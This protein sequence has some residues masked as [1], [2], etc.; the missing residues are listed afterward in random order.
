MEG[1]IPVFP[2]L[3]GKQGGSWAREGGTIQDFSGAV[4][5]EGNPCSFPVTEEVVLAGTLDMERMPFP[6]GKAEYP[7]TC[8]TMNVLYWVW[9]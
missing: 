5:T 2:I 7:A 3:M 6:A 1:W 4:G 9:T 8:D